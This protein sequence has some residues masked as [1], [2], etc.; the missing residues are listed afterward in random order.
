MPSDVDLAKRELVKVLRE[1]AGKHRVTLALS[2]ESPDAEVQKAFRQV[3]R[4]VH[5]DKGG[6]LAE[7]QKLSATNDTWQD[8]RKKKGTAGRPQ[9]ADE[10]KTSRPK[11]GKSWTVRVATEKKEYR[12]QGQA[13]LLTYQG[14]SADL[15]VL[16]PTWQRFVSFVES[17]LKDW[18]VRL[19]TA[20][21]ETN[22]DGKHHLHT[23]LQFFTKSDDR[24]SSLYV[25]EGVQPNA[26][27]NDLMGE[28]FGGNRYQASVD[29]GQFY[30]WANKLG[31]VADGAG[32]LCRAGNCEPAWVRETGSGL[33]GTAKTTHKYKVSADWPKKL[34][35]DYKLETATFENY[36]YLSREKLAANKRNLELYRTWKHEHDLQVEIEERTKRIKSNPS[37]YTPFSRVPEADD[38]LA[39]FAQDAMRY[40]VLLAHAPSFAGKSE[41]AVSLFKKPLYVEIG[42]ANMWP[43]RMKK[44]DRSVHD[45]LVLD[46]LRD[47]RF[48]EDNQ[49][50]LQGKY[51]RPV[52]L[53]NT[54][55][56]ELA[57]TL[58][59]FRLPMVFTINNDT[60][61]LGLLKTS[62][63]LKKRRNVCVLSFSGRP[64]ECPPSQSLPEPA[65]AKS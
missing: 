56:G 45:G 17:K 61:N 52:E 53:F 38:W 27:A 20:T 41:W 49:E 31:T 62:D 14:F 18:G 22:D 36:L 47:L 55:G 26:S 37:L 63:F 6:D 10:D 33:Q 7:F 2:R 34:W 11:A 48:L 43:A 54:P 58:D 4:K 39:E 28:G 59:L 12:V 32:K 51:N 13:V 64:G 57:V 42:S 3:S 8:L 44:L 60:K 21:A 29:R 24:V 25:F 46:D 19:W 50:K 1:L 9:K 23:M 15:A 40:P 30:C 16:L 35:Q 5:P 65:E